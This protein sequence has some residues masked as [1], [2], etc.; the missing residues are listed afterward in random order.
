MAQ[1][2]FIQWVDKYFPSITVRVVE[3]FNDDKRQPSYLY[4]RMLTP[5]YNASGKWDTLSINNQIVMADVIAMDSS[6]PVKSRPAVARASGDIPKVGMEL[7][8]N[9]KQLTDLDTLIAQ[10]G[11]QQQIVNVL[12]NDIPKV[13]GGVLERNERIFLE[14]LSTGVALVDTD[15][16]GTGVRIDYGYA[17]ANKRGVAVIWNTANAAT[18]TPVTDIQKLMDV[19]NANGDTPVKV[20]MDMTALAGFTASAEAKGNFA[21]LGG[22][23]T[24][25]ANIPTLGQ[26]QVQTLFRDKWGIDLEIVNRTVK[27]QIDKTIT[28]LKPWADGRVVFVSNN[29][30][31][32]LE[33]SR[34]AE[35]NHPVE[36]VNYQTADGYILVSKYRENRPSLREFTSSQARVVPVINADGIYTLD[37]KTVQA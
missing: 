36:G 22:I 21:F 28:N 29:N 24:S 20:L 8:L 11:T 27:Y 2:L 6:L 3:K 37:T 35:Q 5:A 25:A 16:E 23:S 10:G 14:G 13:I 1:S 7:F 12:F 17:A 30:V 34:L 4:K 15:N 32:N 9:E 19:A 31:G 18:S 33:Y 26:A